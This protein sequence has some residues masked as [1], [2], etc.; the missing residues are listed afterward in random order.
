MPW[1]KSS[2]FFR[3]LQSI[4]PS[5]AGWYSVSSPMIHVS[6]LHIKLSKVK[7]CH[8]LL[9]CPCLGVSLWK[10]FFLQPTILEHPQYFY[11]FIQSCSQDFT[12][13][14]KLF[15]PKS[16]DLIRFC[17]FPLWYLIQLSGNF[18]LL[19]PHCILPFKCQLFSSSVNPLSILP[20]HNTGTTCSFPIFCC[21]FSIRRLWLH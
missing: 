19:N 11:T 13:G 17:P 9:P 16:L 18:I 12:Y 2:L 10:Y 6:S 7:V 15:Q 4:N 14:C 20:L 1:S 8:F 21:F 5:A 3:Q